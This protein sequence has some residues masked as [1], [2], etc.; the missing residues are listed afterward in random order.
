MIHCP[1]KLLIDLENSPL[2][3]PENFENKNNKSKKHAIV[4]DAIYKYFK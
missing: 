2:R 3:S 4:F 1:N